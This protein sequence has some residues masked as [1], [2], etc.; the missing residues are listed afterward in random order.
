MTEPSEPG[1]KPSDITQLLFKAVKA[2]PDDEQQAIFAYF[3]ERGIGVPQPPFFEQFVHEGLRPPEGAGAGDARSTDSRRM[4]VVNML[5]ARPAGPNHQVI[6][7]RLSE[8][9]HRRLKEWCAEHNFPMA[10]VVRGLIDRFLD[11]WQE[12]AA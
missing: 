1:G 4:S 6:P 12:R 7:V 10:V 2:L 11:S 3:F 8:D 5:T 9:S